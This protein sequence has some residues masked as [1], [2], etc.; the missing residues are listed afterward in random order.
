MSPPDLAPRDPDYAARIARSFAR[1]A[2]MAHLGA[3]LVAV[4]PGRVEI[5][6]AIRP[7][8]LQQHG[9][10]HAGVAWSIADT[11]AGFAAQS[12]MPPERTVLTVELK[13]NLMAPARGARLEARGHVL[14]AGRTLIT[15]RA[16]VATLDETGAE[17]A[18]AEALGTFIAADGIPERDG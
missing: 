10:A 3:E 15:A 4:A 8:L 18:V 11:A 17:T 9:F 16:E 2:F 6:V 14:R 5:A 1:Q 12:L 13:I 7:A